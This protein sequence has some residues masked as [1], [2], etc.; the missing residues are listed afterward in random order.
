MK[1]PFTTLA[2]CA[3]TINNATALTLLDT[4]FRPTCITAP[5][6]W[7]NKSPPLLEFCETAPLEPATLRGAQ[8]CLAN[9][10][11]TR[12][13]DEANSPRPA[14]YNVGAEP[15]AMGGHVS[16]DV[17]GE[18]VAS[19][20]EVW[21]PNGCWTA[22]FP[23]MLEAF[24]ERA[25]RMCVRPECKDEKWCPLSAKAVAVDGSFEV[26]LRGKKKGREEW[27][28]MS[29]GEGMVTLRP[30]PSATLEL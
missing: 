1:L 17:N 13:D 25:L 19:V 23:D 22:V 6:T 5:S 9:I 8:M 11:S 30:S 2:L 3:A 16:A 26:R 18:E 14:A 12:R 27:K 15:K 10:R 20:V 21:A 4:S 24:V 28:T 29:V 7:L